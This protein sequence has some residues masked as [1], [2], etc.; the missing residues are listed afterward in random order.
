LSANTSQINTGISAY[1]KT[2][3]TID[4]AAAQGYFLRRIT[5]EHF[6]ILF[7]AKWS[8]RL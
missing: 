4:N 7:L 2:T 1:A 8:G 3:S 5:L 6:A